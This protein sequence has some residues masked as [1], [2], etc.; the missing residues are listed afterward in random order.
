MFRIHTIL[1]PV[2]FSDASRKAL[3]Y[4]HEFALGMGASITLLHIIDIPIDAMM[5]NMQFE[6]SLETAVQEDLDAFRKTLF[7]EGLKVEKLIEYGN[8]ADKILER[9]SLHD[10]NLI[11]MGSHGKKWLSRLILGSVAEAVVRK[12]CCPVLIVKDNEIEFI[13]EEEKQPACQGTPYP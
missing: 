13:G 6:E 2:D 11:I 10:V 5:G 8:P 7:A 12:A 3:N 4:A 1:C 9:A